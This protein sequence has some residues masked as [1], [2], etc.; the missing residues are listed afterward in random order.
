LVEKV[1]SGIEEKAS[2]GSLLSDD[3]GALI[4]AMNDEQLRRAR[5]LIDVRLEGLERVRALIAVA[6]AM[7]ADRREPTIKEALKAIKALASGEDRERGYQEI[8]SLLTAGQI[9][10]VLA[11]AE[12][13]GEPSG[14]AHLAKMLP[15]LSGSVRERA[16]E[17][18]VCHA[19]TV[20]F[21]KWH[22]ALLAIPEGLESHALDALVEVARDLDVTHGKAHLLTALAPRVTKRRRGRVTRDALAAIAGCDRHRTRVELLLELGRV[23]DA[24]REFQSAVSAMPAYDL[25]A[26]VALLAPHVSQQRRNEWVGLAL[27]AAD[28]DRDA[29]EKIADHLT[30]DQAQGYLA[31]WIVERLPFDILQL[32]QLHELQKNIPWIHVEHESSVGAALARRMAVLG[33][34]DAAFA[35]LRMGRNDDFTA[36]ALVELAPRL[37]PEEVLFVEDWVRTA[38]LEKVAVSGRVGKTLLSTTARSYLLGR[39]AP[40]LARAGEVRRAVQYAEETEI[41]WRVASYLGIAEATNDD[42]RKHA[43]LQALRAV[44]EVR[45]VFRS[46]QIYGAARAIAG[47]AATA[48]AA[49]PIALKWASAHPRCDAIE[50]IAAFAPVAHAIGGSSLP[51]QTFIAIEQVLRWWP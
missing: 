10:E 51:D 23:N 29:L 5:R 32:R 35:L 14:I 16:I 30:P 43:L 40:S 11:A 49:W 48:A 21:E 28:E 3:D 18:F 27:A 22:D 25:V 33:K 45:D 9:T 39:L 17:S 36:T 41:E 31:K 34:A 8:A 6:R 24:A 37:S 50:V 12:R 47:D 1:L 13:I 44:F 26:S 42:M 2:A 15:Y 19:Q 38:K 4:L 46:E 7:P 20:P